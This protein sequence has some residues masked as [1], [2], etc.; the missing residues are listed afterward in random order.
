MGGQSSEQAEA[1]DWFIKWSTEQ[2]SQEAAEETRMD[3][4]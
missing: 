4:P 3:L 2:E 1:P